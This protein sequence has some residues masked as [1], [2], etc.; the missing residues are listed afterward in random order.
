MY[1]KELENA[2]YRIWFAKV[3]ENGEVLS[4]EVYGRKYKIMGHAWN[5]GVK[6]SYEK[7]PDY[8]FRVAKRNPW[9][10]YERTVT[11]ERCGEE[12]LAPE[13]PDGWSSPSNCSVFD[14]DSEC[15]RIHKILCPDCIGKIKE[16]LG[17]KEED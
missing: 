3:D 8:R 15:R 6:L 11:C 14:N 13:A 9:K 16:F 17:V 1:N 5:T 2:P 4:T 12:F 10:E 7:G